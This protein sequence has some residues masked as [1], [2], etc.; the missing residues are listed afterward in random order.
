MPRPPLSERE[1]TVLAI[2]QK[3]WKYPAYKEQAI[4]N[5]LDLNATRYYQILNSLLDHPQALESY[6]ILINRLRTVLPDE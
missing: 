3:R 4:R 1:L 5:Q 2:E 6:P